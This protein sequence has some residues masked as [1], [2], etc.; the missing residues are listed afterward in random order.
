MG[1]KNPIELEYQIIKLH[2]EGYSDAEIGR[3]IGHYPGYVR[4]VR[5]KYGFAKKNLSPRQNDIKTLFLE[6]K[7]IKCIADMRGEPQ[8]NIRQVLQK[9]NLLEKQ[10]PSEKECL[11][12]G[13]KFIGRDDRAKYCCKACQAEASHKVHDAKRRSRL[14]SAIIDDDITL[15][16]LIER[17]NSICYICGEPIDLNDYKIVNGRKKPLKMYPTMD[18]VIPLIEGGPHSWDNIKL[19]HLHCNAAKGARR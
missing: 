15:P 19:A 13:K 1:R 11:N 14:R 2:K 12:C 5:I 7:S 4:G 18:H 17:D 9:M 6:G 16:K 3:T 8:K 10:T